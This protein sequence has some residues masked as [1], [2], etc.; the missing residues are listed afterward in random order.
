M[1]KFQY[2]SIELIEQYINTD[3]DVELNQETDLSQDIYSFKHKRSDQKDTHET[4][5]LKRK[6]FSI[7][8]KQVTQCKINDQIS[9]YLVQKR[10]KKEDKHYFQFIFTDVHDTL[11][12]MKQLKR[13][14]TLDYEH[15]DLMLQMIVKSRLSRQIKFDLNQLDDMFKVF[16]AF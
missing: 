15:E 5:Q 4:N 16:F 11:D 1:L 14:S 2:K 6:C 8:S 3:N 10:K 7:S 12:L 9:P 13:A